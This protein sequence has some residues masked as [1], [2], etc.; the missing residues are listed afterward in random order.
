MEY[1]HQSSVS[2]TRSLSPCWTLAKRQGQGQ[3]AKDRKPS[4][5]CQLLALACSWRRRGPASSSD[6]NLWRSGQS[7]PRPG[8]CSLPAGGRCG[9]LGVQQQAGSGAASEH[10]LLLIVDGR[11][12]LVIGRF[13][14]LLE[15]RCTSGSTRDSEA[16]TFLSVS[17]SSAC[18]NGLCPLW[19]SQGWGILRLLVPEAPQRSVSGQAA[20]TVP[21]VGRCPR[22]SAHPASGRG[23]GFVLLL[24]AF[25]LMAGL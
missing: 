9:H 18:V 21:S 14:E 13:I 5:L 15:G 22:T 23:P 24:L 6:A 17:V 10:P 4:S 3:E 8:S 16:E 20:Q 2:V 25:Y 7:S 12:V 11:V 1:F 19:P